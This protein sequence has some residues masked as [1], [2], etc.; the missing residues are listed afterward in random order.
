[1]GSCCDCS[2]NNHIFSPSS[3]PGTRF[4]EEKKEN[5]KYRDFAVGLSLFSLNLAL[6]K[7]RFI[8]GKGEISASFFKKHFKENK[9]G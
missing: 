5:I 9:R 1:M 2:K 7:I 8:Y 4:K 3:L 6:F